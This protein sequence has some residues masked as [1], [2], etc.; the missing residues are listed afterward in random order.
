MTGVVMAD[1]RL[2]RTSRFAPNETQT[3][4]MQRKRSLNSVVDPQPDKNCRL[5][6][7]NIAGEFGKLPLL[8][9]HWRRHSEML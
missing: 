3:P 5:G 7:A 6:I 1:L 8:G 9:N 2:S 4:P